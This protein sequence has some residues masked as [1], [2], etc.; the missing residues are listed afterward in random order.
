MKKFNFRAFISLSVT[1]QFILLGITGI[2]LYIAPRGRTAYWVNWRFLGFT[3]SQWEAT[4]TILG[5][6][7]IIFISIHLYYNWKVVLSYVKNKITKKL[8]FTRELLVSMLVVGFMFFSAA[9]NI[10]PASFVISLGDNITD[11]WDKLAEDLPVPHAELMTIKELSKEIN[12]DYML[13]KSRLI[14][15]SVKF[16]E[17]ETLKEIAEKNNTTPQELYKIMT[18]YTEVNNSSHTGS[19]RKYGYGLMSIKKISADIDKT[20]AEII[21]LLEKKGFKNIDENSVLR[22]IASQKG[23]TPYEVYEIITK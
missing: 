19:G 2:M 22:D 4:H 20:P 15:A 23:Y 12:K 6:A 14:K 5:Y 10:P 3:K 21:D 13:I 18:G 16:N 17:E 9:V 7:F 1:F 11:S 8:S